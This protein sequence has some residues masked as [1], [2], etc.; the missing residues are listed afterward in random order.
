MEEVDPILKDI[1]EVLKKHGVEMRIRSDI[2]F[3]KVEDDNKD[4]KTE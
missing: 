1:Q 3:A 4:G 2:F